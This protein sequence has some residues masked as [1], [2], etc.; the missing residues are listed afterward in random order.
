MATPEG[1]GGGEG[2]KGG[3]EGEEENKKLKEKNTKKEEEEEEDEEKKT[4][5]FFPDC[6][7]SPV[8]GQEETQIPGRLVSEKTLLLMS[9]HIVYI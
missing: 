4:R 9:A 8:Q 2:R 6:E 5:K 7:R 1:S 3:E